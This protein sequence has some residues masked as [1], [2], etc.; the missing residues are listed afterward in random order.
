MEAKNQLRF[1]RVLVAEDDA[2]LRN[3]IRFNLQQAGFEVI[4][5]RDG[6]EAWS[7][8]QQQPSDTVVTD[9]QMPQ[10]TG[11]DLIEALRAD[12]RFDQLPVLLLTAKGL[13]LDYERLRAVL[14]VS[15]IMFKPFS[16]KQ[17]TRVVAQL[18]CLPAEQKA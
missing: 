14:G 15:E 4:A 11:I 6:A 13:E 8:L 7:Q 18:V 17:L 16:P 1:G 10:M 9:L 5:T 3:V 12:G 2:A